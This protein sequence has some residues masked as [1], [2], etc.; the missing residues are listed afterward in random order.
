MMIPALFSRRAFIRSASLVTLAAAGGPALAQTGGNPAAAPSTFRA[1]AVDV[2]PMLDHGGGASAR[3]L[4]EVLLVQMRKVFADRITPGAA[5]A[6]LLTARITSLFLG[7]YVG[8]EDNLGFGN[9]DNIEGDGIVSA[10]GQ[11]LSTTHILTEL[12]PSYS[13]PYY[14]PNIDQIRIES[15]AYQFAYWLRREMGI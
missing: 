3:A 1:V 6:P 9:N 12:P 2:T 5:G 7:S 4:G 8:T 13:G 14:A 11:V 10:G 15:I